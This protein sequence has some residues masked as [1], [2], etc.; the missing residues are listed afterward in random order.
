[1]L[2][3]D[4]IFGVQF[5]EYE[6]DCMA[7]TE[8]PGMGPQQSEEDGSKTPRHTR[9][10]SSHPTVS[11]FFNRRGS[12]SRRSEEKSGRISSDVRSDGNESSLETRMNS[13]ES[14]GPGN[15][16]WSVAAIPGEIDEISPISEMEEGRKV[17]FKGPVSVPLERKGY[18]ALGVFGTLHYGAFRYMLRCVEFVFR[19]IGLETSEETTSEYLENRYI[20]LGVFGLALLLYLRRQSFKMMMKICARCIHAIR[21]P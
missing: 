18:N 4:E 10:S 15:F 20:P 14:G 9:V 11:P 19:S 13:L 1:V 5:L 6:I 7:E 16:D 12:L 17:E 21:P 8:A 3:Q 2:F